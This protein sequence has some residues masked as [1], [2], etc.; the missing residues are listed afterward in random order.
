MISLEGDEDLPRDTIVALRKRRVSDKAESIGGFIFELLIDSL[1]DT[2]I[3]PATWAVD[4]ASNYLSYVEDENRLNVSTLY[5]PFELK[6][7]T[8]LTK[9]LCNQ[10]LYVA[11][12]ISTS[13]DT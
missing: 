1:G 4:A 12:S 10:P 5:E 3:V 8:E 7:I 13:L 9:W 11:F 6:T 2:G